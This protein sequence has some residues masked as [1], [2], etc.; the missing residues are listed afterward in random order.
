MYWG[1][2][3]FWERYREKPIVI[4]ENGLSSRDWPSLD[5]QVHDA[6]RID[7]TAGADHLVELRRAL[8]D[9]RCRF[10]A[11]FHWSF[12]DKFRMGARFTSTALA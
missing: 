3:L 9:G 10:E 5:G 6:E 7:F 11:Y 12:I 1:P 8:A 4:T 2:R